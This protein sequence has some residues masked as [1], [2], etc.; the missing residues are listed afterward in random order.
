VPII[1]SFY[2]IVVYFFYLDNMKHHLPHIHVKYG[3]FE[4]AIAIDEGDILYG[5]LPRAQ[6]KLIQAWIEIHKQELI[7]DWDLAVS[8]H[9]PN[10]IDPLR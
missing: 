1:S 4:A 2:G 7:K 8:G 3:D 10:K 9:K 5:S 6:M